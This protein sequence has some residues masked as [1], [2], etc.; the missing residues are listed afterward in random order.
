MSKLR[1]GVGRTDITPPV[2][3][4]HVNWGA[5]VHDRAEGIDLDLW[6]TAMIISDENTTAVLVDVDFGSF[7]MD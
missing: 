2:G 7:Q 6:A 5:R 3:I 4:A 1:V